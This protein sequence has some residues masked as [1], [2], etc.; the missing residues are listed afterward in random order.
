MEKEG[1]ECNTDRKKNRVKRRGK[2][3]KVWILKK[4]RWQRKHFFSF[5]KIY[6]KNIRS[7]DDFHRSVCLDLCVL[8]YTLHCLNCISLE[9]FHEVFVC[10][11]L[12]YLNCIWNKNIAFPVLSAQKGGFG[13]SL[14][15]YRMESSSLFWC[16]HYSTPILQ[17]SGGPENC[18]YFHTH[19]LTRVFS[20]LYSSLTS[21]QNLLYGSDLFFS[22]LLEH[23]VHLY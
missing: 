22:L 6:C 7:L 21:V 8:D 20:H 12:L 3:K 11:I 9:Y 13:C 1:K 15:N 5:T 17:I 4:A 16:Y 14:C 19:I 2:E 23:S 18:L 10:S